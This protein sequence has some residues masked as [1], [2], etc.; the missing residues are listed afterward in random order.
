MNAVDVSHMT[1]PQKLQALEVIWD[2]LIHE[3]AELDS[4]DWHN[5]VLMARKQA[6]ADGSANYL[7]LQQLKAQSQK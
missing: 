7:T 3:D 5:E 2:S 6:I 4:P 1:K